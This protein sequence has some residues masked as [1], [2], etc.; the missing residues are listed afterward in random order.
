MDRHASLIHVGAGISGRFRID[1]RNR[2]SEVIGIESSGCPVLSPKRGSRSGRPGGL[3]RLDPLRRVGGGNAGVWVAPGLDGFR[4]GVERLLKHGLGAEKPP[5]LSSEGVACF[6]HALLEG[7]SQVSRQ[8]GRFEVRELR[9][10]ARA[11]S[12]IEDAPPQANA[13]L[14]DFV[15]QRHDDRR[16][17]RPSLHGRLPRLFAMS[18]DGQNQEKRD[19]MHEAMA[20]VKAHVRNGYFVSDEP[21]NLPEGTPVELQLVTTDPWADMDPEERAELEESIE[22][23]FRDIENG[24]VVDA[25][26]FLAELRAKHP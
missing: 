7:G 18:P 13:A 9:G 4:R 6:A 19:M 1:S 22:E 10:R 12:G 3:D 24:D 20:P 21:A 25:R 23:G 8:R 5:A 14:A 16:L 2:D 15:R 11:V 17:P 26:E